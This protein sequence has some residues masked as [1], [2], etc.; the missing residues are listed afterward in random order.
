MSRGYRSVL[1][2]AGRTAESR[3]VV[4]CEHEL[5][6]VDMDEGTATSS[7]ARRL[8]ADLLG[9]V[10]G[11]MTKTVVS[12]SSAM[13][14]SDA[15]AFLHRNGV[16][17]AP[18]IEHERVVG[19]I[20]ISDLQG[21]HPYAH[22]TGPFLRPHKGGSQW[23]VTDLMTK[24]AITAFPDEPLVDAVVRMT[25]E[26][27]DRLP[28]VDRDGRP[29]GIVAREDVVRVLAR[30]ARQEARTEPPRPVLLPR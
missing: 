2:G 7:S 8:L 12:V 4:V 26:R 21:P 30:A 9:S 11:A 5:G 29:I 24:T 1:P 20:T 28:V 17:G 22:E 15:L 16:G 6:G 14:A 19:V 13:S 3:T 18:V 25:R 23:Q 27:V 10:E